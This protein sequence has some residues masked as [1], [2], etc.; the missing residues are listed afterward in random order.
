MTAHDQPLQGKVAVI[1]GAGRGIGRAVALGYARAGAAVVCAARSDA[2]IE[3]TVG[4]IREAGGSAT[5]CRVDV[6]DYASVQALFAHATQA[7][8]GVDIVLANAGVGGRARTEDSDP[9]QWAHMIQVNLV[10]AFHTAHAAL[11]HLRA[12]GAGK[13]IFTGSGSRHGFAAGQGSYSASKAALWKFVQVLATELLDTRI[14]VN[15]LVPGPVRTEM[16]DFGKVAYFP[17]TEWVKEP[18]DVVPMALFLATQPDHGPTAQS[19][20]IMRRAG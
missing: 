2:E 20:S 10:G 15:E 17:A 14:S 9:A 4:A 12:R 5:A 13:L 18:E 8:G 11:P 16:T 19:F 7:H 3:A 6:T 1:T